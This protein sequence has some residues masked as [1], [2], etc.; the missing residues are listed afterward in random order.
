IEPVELP[1]DLAYHL[2]GI[3]RSQMTNI[4][5]IIRALGKLGHEAISAPIISLTKE[6]DGKKSLM[7][8]PFEDLSPTGDNAWFADGI[9]S[10]L[11]GTLSNLKSLRLMDQQETKSFKTF[12]GHLTE[13]ARTMNVRYFVQGS[14]RKFGDQIKIMTQLLDIQT[15]D[16]LWQD[17][18]KGTMDDIFEIQE[19]VAKKV[20]DGLILHLNTDE[21]KKLTEHGTENAEAYE[22]YLKANEYFE[23]NT[24]EGFQLADQL[25]IEAIR[26]DPIYARAY[27][28]MAYTLLQI[29][30]SYD[31]N[32]DLLIEAEAL[33]T[34]A[35]RL[36]PLLF[37]TYGPLSQLYMYQGKLTEAEEIAKEFIRLDPESWQSHH[38]LSY[39][40]SEIGSVAKAIGPA[41][42]SIRLNT[43]SR[44]NFWNIIALY[45]NL[46]DKENAKYWSLKALP[47]FERFAKLHPNDEVSNSQCACLLFFAGH[48]ED[49]KRVIEELKK[50]RDGSSLMNLA[51]IFCLMRER[52]KA[53]ELMQM[54]IEAGFRNINY[55]RSFITDKPGDPVIFAGAPLYG[56]I[57]A[58]IEKLEAEEAS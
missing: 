41:L 15:G 11:I 5:A 49:A 7:I 58:M 50:S 1:D 16:Y 32:P 56:E 45:T 48:T 14:V 2:A 38:T 20:V 55:L 8:L 29:Y 46:Q 35:L 52:D 21:K 51:N 40:Y 23:R 17:T 12:K 19:A 6:A 3:Q 47:L 18:H 57:N 33:C 39:F 30:R 42:E 9:A 31:R 34:E 27:V 36:K 4:D 24:K 43:D 10:E 44:I 22:L 37:A 26:L 13:Y 53:L 25:L 28:M 54:A